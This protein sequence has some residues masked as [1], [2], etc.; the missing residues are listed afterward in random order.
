MPAARD[1]DWA[2]VHV[3]GGDRAAAEPY[4]PYA[5]K[6]LGF[7]KQD[8]QANRLRTHQATKQLPDG[9]LVVAE[10]VGDIPRITITPPPGGGFVEEVIY[11]YAS[12]DGGLRIF[13]LGTRKLVKTITGLGDYDLQAVSESGLVAWMTYQ[14]AAISAAVIARVDIAATTAAGRTYPVQT[15]AE[16]PDDPPVAGTALDSDAALLSPDG[17]RLLLRFSSSGV[18]SAIREGVGGVLLV[19]TETLEPL[20]APIRMTYDPA[21]MAWAPDSSRF[22]LGCALPD[23]VGDLPDSAGRLAALTTSSADYVAAFDADG[24]L[25]GA[26]QVSTWDEAPNSGFS[27]HVKGLAATADR[28]YASV[29]VPPTLQALKA[30]DLAPVATLDLSDLGAAAP[31][32]LCLARDGTRLFLANGDA[33]GVAALAN[34]ELELEQ[35]VTHAEYATDAPLREPAYPVL[36]LGPRSRVGQPPDDRRFFLNTDGD[37]RVLRAFR[38]FDLHE[39][40]PRDAYQFDLAEWAVDINYRL[41]AVGIRRHPARTSA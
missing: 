35:V 9:A 24:V 30:A 8:A 1:S 32:L 11:L 12:S 13:D 39:G 29:D 19:D 20:R 18:A 17:K 26:Q 25:L 2:H 23:D 5:R 33:V 21:P 7:V 38:Q 15:P 6:L 27:R 16:D 34:D 3:A 28:V 4:L 22:Y 31:P 10:I 40:A 37:S 14:P 36:Q 41:A